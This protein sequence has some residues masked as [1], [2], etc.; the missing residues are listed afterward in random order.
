ML[1]CFVTLRSI[2]QHAKRLYPLQVSPKD[3]LEWGYRNVDAKDGD[4][5]SEVEW[6]V[7]DKSALEGVDA[8]GLD[9]RI[10]FEGTAD[11]STGYYCFYNEG[12]LVN[13]SAEG[14]ELPAGVAVSSKPRKQM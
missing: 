2:V 13:G 5:G 12:R 1:V 9:R 14:N 7:A 8:K 11:P 3:T 4:G 10:G 6:S